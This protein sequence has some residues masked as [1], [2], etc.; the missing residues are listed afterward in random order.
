MVIVASGAKF[1]KEGPPFQRDPMLP[2]SYKL[3]TIC[4]S[5]ATQLYA[6]EL[7]RILSQPGASVLV[8]FCVCTSFWVE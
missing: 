7:P 4:S 6:V 5:S 3:V 1:D 2:K 8:C